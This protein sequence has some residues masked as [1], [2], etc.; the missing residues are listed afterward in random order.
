MPDITHSFSPRVQRR[1]GVCL[2]IVGS[3]CLLFAIKWSWDETWFAPDSSKTVGTVVSIDERGKR[4][5]V[6]FAGGDGVPVRFHVRSSNSYFRVGERVEVRYSPMNPQDAK[7][8]ALF[9][10]WCHTVIFTLFGIAC[11][12]FGELTR[13]G[14][15]VAG[16]L[17]QR[18][19][20][21]SN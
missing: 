1:L 3:V 11:L 4:A 16:P 5:L 12:I 19:I 15:M 18:R 8:D 21:I 20:F 7:R 14:R 6:D 17:K 13:T 10:L 2:L 9:D